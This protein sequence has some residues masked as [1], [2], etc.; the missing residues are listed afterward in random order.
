MPRLP[1]LNSKQMIKA[2]KKAGF[3]VDHQTGSH[4]IMYKDDQSS[5]VSVPYHNKDL[6]LGTIKNIL[7]QAKLTVEELIK[8]L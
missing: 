2:L 7:N 6:K 5:L 4:V 1:R 3:Y 8:N